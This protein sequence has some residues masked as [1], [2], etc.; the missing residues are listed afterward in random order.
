MSQRVTLEDIARKSGVSPATVS[1]VLRDK[2][3]ITADTRQRVIEA[4]RE[5]GYARLSPAD[6]PELHAIV[7]RLC[8]VADLVKPTIVLERQAL[9]NSW[10][11]GTV[12]GGYRLHLTRGLVEALEPREP[13][14]ARRVD[15]RRREGRRPQ[16]RLV[17]RPLGQRLGAVQAARVVRCGAEGR[18]E[19]EVAGPGVL[20]RPQQATAGT[21]HPL[22]SLAPSCG[23]RDGG[24]PRGSA[25][26]RR[27]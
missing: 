20:G 12:R 16:R 19:D 10:I 17:H 18:E 14:V 9:P 22:S 25:S 11:E 27:W 13:A 23:G 4:A 26:R 7:E 21:T 1:L 5:L 8:V 6:A 24:R 3:G 2:P 15:E